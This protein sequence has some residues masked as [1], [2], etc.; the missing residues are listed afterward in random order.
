MKKF[1][2]GEVISWKVGN[3]ETK[4]A[5]L[6]DNGDTLEVFTHSIGNRKDNRTIVIQKSVLQNDCEHKYISREDGLDK[7]L[8]CGTKN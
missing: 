3:I 4:A 7:C 6:N 2:I 5:V 1:E 8:D